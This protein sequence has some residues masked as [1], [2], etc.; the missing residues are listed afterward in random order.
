MQYKGDMWCE[1]RVVCNLWQTSKCDWLRFQSGGEVLVEGRCWLG[2][3]RG[4]AVLLGL[5]VA[6]VFVEG[7]GWQYHDHH[8][9]SR[10]YLCCSH[11]CPSNPKNLDNGLP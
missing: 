9:L 5:T 4:V 2:A 3:T 11:W 8:D 10:D 6:I 7:C 1:V